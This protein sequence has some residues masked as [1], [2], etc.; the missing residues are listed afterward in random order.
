MTA[1]GHRVRFVATWR[2]E[3]FE[4]PISPFLDDEGLQ[5]IGQ[6]FDATAARPIQRTLIAR[7]RDAKESEVLRS[8]QHE[9]VAKDVKI[10]IYAITHDPALRSVP[11][12]TFHA[13]ILLADFD[14]AYIGSSNMNRWSR[15]FSMECG[16]VIRGPGARPAAT[17]VDA[18]LR[19]SEPWQF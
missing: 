4:V 5:W 7:G 2:E 11:I 10:L 15:D 3:F 17:L 16:V 13:K 19:I 9:L 18:L 14:K 8:H 6:L 12:E 1:H